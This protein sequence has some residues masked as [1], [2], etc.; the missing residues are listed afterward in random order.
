MATTL[1]RQTTVPRIL[2][3]VY[4]HLIS[5]LSNLQL[6]DRKNCKHYAAAQ[7]ISSQERVPEAAGDDEDEPGGEVG[8]GG[9]DRR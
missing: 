3:F 9:G 5:T 4:R 1:P 8:H 7:C 6:S 2:A